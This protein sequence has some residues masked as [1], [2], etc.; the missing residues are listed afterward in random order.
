[1][2][3]IRTVKPELASDRKLASVSI[4]ARYAFVLL[5]SQA[6]DDGLLR[7]EPR[8]LL[9]SLYPHDPTVTEEILEVWLNELIGSGMARW[10]YTRDG[11]RVVEVVNWSRHQCIKNRSK[12]FLLNQL[13]EA[14]EPPL[15]RSSVDPTETLPPSYGDSGGAESRV[16]SLESR[17]LCP[18]PNV[19]GGSPASQVNGKVPRTKRGTKSRD[20]P[21]V[22]RRATWVQEAHGI[23][24]AQIG[25][26]D[27]GRLGRL[28]KPLVEEHGWETVK[29]IWEWFCEFSPVEWYLDRIESGAF[30]NREEKPV[31]KFGWHTK[32]EA[33]VERFTH[34]RAKAV[35]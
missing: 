13:T 6:D 23:Y 28:L 10:R 33:F 1:M 25:H 31:K 3:R 2:P 21:Q 8:Q 30:S 4:F 11:M 18:S 5:I 9:G 15:S 35:A 22:E 17:A 16:L 29:P 7:A 12:P 26:V 32:P 34:Y 20:A 24:M 27:F 14:T 19:S